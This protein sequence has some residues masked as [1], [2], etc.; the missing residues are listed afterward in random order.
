MAQIS[1]KEAFREN[2]NARLEALGVYAYT[3]CK[4]HGKKGGWLTDTLRRSPKGVSLDVKDEIADMLGVPRNSIDKPGA[5]MTR[6]KAP[7]WVAKAKAQA[8][9]AKS[10]AAK[11][12]PK[13]V[14]EAQAARMRAALGRS[15][16]A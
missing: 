11:K 4:A 13:E 3:A 7:A 1:S 9:K 8:A 16:E 12:R 10:E 15:K 6:P 5:D 14:Q 2:V